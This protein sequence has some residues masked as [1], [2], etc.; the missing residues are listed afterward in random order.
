MRLSFRP[1][2]VSA[3]WVAFV[4]CAPPLLS[5]LQGGGG[6]GTGSL[7][8]SR[9]IHTMWFGP[10]NLFT[11][12]RHRV[13][14][15][16]VLP[17]GSRVEFGLTALR[18][19]DVVEWKGAGAIALP[20]ASTDSCE[21]LFPSAGPVTV[22]CTILPD[23]ESMDCPLLVLPL[24]PDQVS[25]DYLIQR[26]QPFELEE[27]LGNE[28]TVD[29]WKHWDSIAK[30]ERVGGQWVTS[31][32]TQSRGPGR[33]VLNACPIPRP[34]LG[35]IPGIESLLEWRVDGEAVGVGRASPALTKGLHQL[36][37]GPPGYTLSDA[38]F[39]YEV[40]VQSNPP[41][42]EWRENIPIEFTATTDPPG[43][44]SQVTWMSSTLFGKA[45]PTLGSGPTF[46]TQFSGIYGPHGDHLLS[47]TGVLGD[48]SRLGEDC[49][50]RADPLDP[51]SVPPD[52]Y[53]RVFISE[54]EGVRFDNPALG[55]VQQILFAPTDD[56]AQP[57]VPFVDY[58]SEF[59]PAGSTTA[60]FMRSGLYIVRVDWT[61]L[62][63]IFAIYVDCAPGDGGFPCQ[64]APA[65][66]VAKPTEDVKIVECPPPGD[67]NGFDSD[68]KK[69]LADEVGVVDVD[70]AIKAVEDAYNKK[71]DKVSV[72][73][74]GHGTASEISVGDGLKRDD[75][76]RLALDNPGGCKL[77]NKT[78]EFASKLKGKVSTLKLYGCGVGAG[79]SGC[80]FLQELA[81]ALQAKVCAYDGEVYWT[82]KC[83]SKPKETKAVTKCPK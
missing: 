29:I 4:C 64:D 74:C 9:R 67:D 45:E 60:Q 33:L 24:S 41:V 62:R 82:E 20:G 36:E 11:T 35:V 3:L 76:K 50:R 49:F 70:G 16:L 79:N 18:K 8:D 77:T 38:L 72:Y 7:D 61:L 48:S 27:D 78:E 19:T 66:A 5:Q 46:V 34:P 56:P 1:V 15:K 10:V 63:Q 53:P 43:Y 14:Q 40:S 22:S 13:P 31:V 57:Y 81:N 69:A 6:G 26:R 59:C 25:F 75:L 52:F 44:E 71:K 55:Q 65:E 51:N 47:W 68:A 39:A 21:F 28:Q 42:E 32:Q 23:D 73:M 12:A 54:G 80:K 2:T 37:I 30:V 58:W 17:L 83:P